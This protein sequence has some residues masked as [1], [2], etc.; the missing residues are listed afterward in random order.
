MSDCGILH[1]ADIGHVI[2]VPIHIDHIFRN[3]LLVT[4]DCGLRLV[5]AHVRSLI[6]GP[7]SSKDM[8]DSEWR[9]VNPVT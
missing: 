8:Q 7:G 9:V 1:P 2:D 3:D 6:H 5:F 4:E